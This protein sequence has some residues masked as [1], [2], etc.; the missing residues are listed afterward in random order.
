MHISMTVDYIPSLCYHHFRRIKMNTEY[1]SIKSNNGAFFVFMPDQV[2]DPDFIFIAA[3]GLA[4]HAARYGRLSGYLKNHNVQLYC[5]DHLGQGVY[6]TT[7]G[8]WPEN[9][10]D[11]CVENMNRL[12]EYCHQ[13]HPGKKISLFGHSMGSFMCISYCEK[14][15]G[16]INNCILSG[17]NDAQDP[18]LLKTGLAILWIQRL[19]LGRDKKS[20]LIDTM[21]FGSFNKQFEPSRTEFDWLSRDEKEVDKYISD[22]LCGYVSTIGLYTDFFTALTEIYKDE[23]INKIPK[24]LP[25]HLMSGSECAVGEKGKGPIK[26]VSRLENAGMKNV[27][28]KIFE[29]MRHEILNEIG[30]DTVMNHVL[31][32]C[33]KSFNI[34]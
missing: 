28:L 20:K 25:I 5:I 16:L 34:T 9:G 2:A 31:D 1:F 29:D 27:S 32:V 21:S 30:K 15:A 19:F 18:L 33:I 8:V 6:A 13:K 3:P 26:L 17:T 10:F 14:Y 7:P 23:N 4:E 24:N 22:P 12:V 11:K